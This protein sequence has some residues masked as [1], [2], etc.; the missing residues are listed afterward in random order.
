MTPE[1]IDLYR[2]VQHRR[3]ELWAEY[4]KIFCEECGSYDT[5]ISHMNNT[6]CK[7]PFIWIAPVWDEDCPERCL[8]G[9]IKRDFS[10]TRIWYDSDDLTTGDGWIYGV[11][12]IDGEF[13]GYYNSLPEALL[14][15]I[16]EQEGSN[17]DG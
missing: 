15:A 2:S 14:R 1:E 12:F 8:I 17:A 6:N 16:R 13:I 5:A 3:G 10:V 7:G 9:M 4:D 11:D